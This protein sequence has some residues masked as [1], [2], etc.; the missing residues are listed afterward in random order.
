MLTSLVMNNAKHMYAPIFSAVFD[1]QRESQLDNIICVISVLYVRI[2]AH[3]KCLSL[4]WIGYRT[5][6]DPILICV[7][8]WIQGGA[9]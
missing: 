8:W 9:K 6:D 7:W 3:A 5:E 1:H 2:L 4:N